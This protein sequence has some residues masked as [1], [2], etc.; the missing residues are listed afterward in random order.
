MQKTGISVRT[1]SHEV[2]LEGDPGPFAVSLTSESAGPGVDLV[3]LRL[4]AEQPTTPGHIRLALRHPSVNV[5]GRWHP[6]VLHA[7]NLPPDWAPGFMAE[8]ARHAPVVTLHSAGGINQLTLA[9]SDVLN[10]VEIRAGVQEETGEIRCRVHLFA[11]A[12]APVREYDTQVLIDTRAIAYCE[13]IDHVQQWWRSFPGCTPR[14][15]PEAARLPMYSTWYSFHQSIDRDAVLEQCRM[16]REMGCRSLIVDDGW[17][18][19]D[20]RRGY[21]YAGD[22]EPERIGDMRAFVR[23]VHDLGMKFLLWYAVPFVGIHSRAFRRFEGRLLTR[24]DRLQA[25]VLDPRYPEVRDH[26]IGVFERALVDWELDGFKFDFVDEF[27]LRGSEPSEQRPGMDHASVAEAAYRLMVDIFDRLQAIRPDIMVEFRQEYIGPLM[28]RF[29]NMFRAGDCPNDALTN[30]VRTLDIRMLCGETACHSDMYM[31][32]PGDSVE[33]AA[34]QILN[35]LFS[36]PQVSVMLDRLPAD[37]LAMLRFWMRFWCRHRDVLL[38][39]RLQ[40]AHPE[41]LYPLVIATTEAK[42]V[43]A[44]YQELVIAP[45][46][47]VPAELFVVNGTSAGRLVLEL[48][49]SIG[50]RRIDTFNCRGECV[51]SDL[52]EL[53]AGLHPLQVPPAGLIEI[54][55][56]R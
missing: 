30:R 26:L 24:L 44:A 35:T 23:D 9:C 7:R 29:G 18:T 11:R 43:C 38:G 31:W 42:R 19:S 55:S 6:A 39:G 1:S 34:L 21:A 10:P 51:G 54:R 48:A 15:V 14:P 37:H 45:G 33:A 27:A 52:R 3:R 49:E 47:G 17:Q 36:V 22:W 25:G 5:F 53:G 13:A 56:G 46:A 50:T 20:S 40:P 2:S 41:G 16:A 4:R 28:R 12:H 32:H 8:L